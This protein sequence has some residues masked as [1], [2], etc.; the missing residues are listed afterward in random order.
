MILASTFGRLKFSK[1][2][3]TDD[4]KFEF[5]S[6]TTLLRPNENLAIKDLA[7]MFYSSDHV[8]C[9]IN[10]GQN[11]LPLCSWKIEDGD[12][13]VADTCNRNFMVYGNFKPEI[14]TIKFNQK[15]LAF[16]AKHLDNDPS[17]VDSVTVK[18]RYAVMVYANIVKKTPK[19]PTNETDVELHQ[20]RKNSFWSYA[21]NLNGD[22]ILLHGDSIFVLN[23]NRPS[24]TENLRVG[25]AG[26]SFDEF[27]IADNFTLE[28]LDKDRFFANEGQLYLNFDSPYEPKTGSGKNLNTKVPL[29][30]VVY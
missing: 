6:S 28:I 20:A 4:N 21:E 17:T 22:E 13:D 1:F 25:P 7:C 2:Q 24:P 10:T 30:D 11:Y 18:N 9:V 5:I 19:N 26:N 15:Y 27:K 29:A 14:N 3:L 12:K 16:A 23:N 8:Q